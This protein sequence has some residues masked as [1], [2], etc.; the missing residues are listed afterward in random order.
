MIKGIL[1]L[2]VFQFLGEAIA[3]LLTLKIP[4]AIIGLLLLLC[5]LLLRKQSFKSLDSAV[6]F[7][8]KYLVLF[9]IPAALGVVTQIDVISKELLAILVSITIGTILSLALSVKLMDI[10][11]MKKRDKNEL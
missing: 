3:K 8:L 7:L 6:A 9:I 11:I 10:L 4:G 5:F 1:L 2:L